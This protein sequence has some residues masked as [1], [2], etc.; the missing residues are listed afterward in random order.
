MGYVQYHL[1]NQYNQNIAQLLQVS[2]LF[3]TLRCSSNV[4]TPNIFTLQISIHP[5]PSLITNYQ[6]SRKQLLP[7]EK[8]LY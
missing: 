4:T 1:K 3:Q 7:L 8:S 6:S 2:S 5:I